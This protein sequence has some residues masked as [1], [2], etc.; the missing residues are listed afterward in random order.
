MHGVSEDEI[1]KAIWNVGGPPKLSHFAWKACKGSLGVMDVLCRRHIRETSCC[2]VCN[3][4]EETIMHTLFECKHA[5]TIWMQSEFLDLLTEA[6]SGSF[7]DRVRW[8][9]EKVDK[10]QLRTFLAL[11]WAS[12]FCRNKAIFEP[13]TAFDPIGVAT[14]M[15]KLVVDYVE[16]NAKVGMQSRSHHFPSAG[17]WFAPPGNS[18][19]VNVDAHVTHGNGVQLGV[20]IRD[21]AGALMDAAVKSIDADWAPVMAEAGA[22]RYG[23]EL[24][25][26]SGAGS[27]AGLHESDSGE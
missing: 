26:W 15:V 16:Y 14:G 20:V 21:D 24:A 27:T 4:H 17:R 11:A 5:G 19:K 1:W 13:T 7:S 12:W 22:V 8:M 3:H 18:I 23:V 9:A 10:E 2:P 25:L 6:P